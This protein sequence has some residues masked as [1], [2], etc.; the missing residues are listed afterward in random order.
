MFGAAGRNWE[1]NYFNKVVCVED[2]IHLIAKTNTLQ[3]EKGS[4][5]QTVKNNKQLNHYLVAG[6]VEV[7]G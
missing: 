3:N 2:D 4:R 1:N 7:V 5:W 6:F